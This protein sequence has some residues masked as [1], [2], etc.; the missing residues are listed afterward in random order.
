MLKIPYP[1]VGPVQ[2]VCHPNSGWNGYIL[3]SITDT[4]GMETKTTV[5]T[6]DNY[7]HEGEHPLPYTVQ[8]QHQFF[9]D[10]AA[11]E[12]LL[13]QIPIGAVEARTRWT[14]YA[15]ARADGTLTLKTISRS[16]KIPL[17]ARD[18]EW[19][20]SG[21]KK[22]QAYTEVRLTS[23]DGQTV[24]YGPAQRRETTVIIP[25][26]VATILEIGGLNMPYSS[27]D[28][29]WT[30]GNGQAA[31][32]PLAG[33]VLAVESGQPDLNL[34][35]AWPSDPPIDGW[36]ARPS[37]L[38]GPLSGGSE[39]QGV[40]PNNLEYL[41]WGIVISGEREGAAPFLVVRDGYGEYW[42][43]PFVKGSQPT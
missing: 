28:P 13:V 43:L 27:T 9:L 16:L 26:G 11:G 2:M 18:T 36:V 31:L 3:H 33:D 20:F 6:I 32:P 22:G 10:L 4:S 35:Q 21:L 8:A 40:D 30:Y 14:P 17:Q 41:D 19:A 25:A 15:L 34:G 37:D 42:H 38:G 39:A 24:Y 7:G 5:R 29:Q 23:A 12:T 1:V